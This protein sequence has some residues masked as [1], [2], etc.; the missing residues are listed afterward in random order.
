MIGDFLVAMWEKLIK[1][2][3]RYVIVE[4]DKKGVLLRCGQVRKVVGP[5]FYI[6]LP[7]VDD[8]DIITV[9]SQVVDLPDVSVQTKDGVAVVASGVVSYRIVDVV[10]AMYE[11]LDYDAALRT[12]GSACLA[13]AVSKM[14]WEGERE[15]LGGELEEELQLWVRGWGLAVESFVINRLAKTIGLDVTMH[16]AGNAEGVG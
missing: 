15:G 1:L 10:K 7:L 4:P 16:T 5:G 8:A 6:L 9:V 11:V 3:P 14:E 13:E 2:F 12:I